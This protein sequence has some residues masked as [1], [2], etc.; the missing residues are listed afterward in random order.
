MYFL[1]ISAPEN[2]VQKDSI[3]RELPSPRSRRNHVCFYASVLLVL[4]VS[5]TLAVTRPLHLSPQA[6]HPDLSCWFSPTARWGSHFSIC[7][8]ALVGDL[9]P[10]PRLSTSDY[11]TDIKGPVLAGTHTLLATPH[12]ST[13]HIRTLDLRERLYQDDGIC[14]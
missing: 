7:L 4:T 9:S 13:K 2:R 5:G 12:H 3:P 6:S 1:L 8:L 11:L 14:R 10:T